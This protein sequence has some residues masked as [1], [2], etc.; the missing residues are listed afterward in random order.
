MVCSSTCSTDAD[1]RLPTAASESQVTSRAP[2]VRSSARLIA[3]STFGPPGCATQVPTSA[4]VMPWSARKLS[5]SAR[6]Y[7]STTSGTVASS[8]IRKPVVPMSQPI[9]RSVS[10][11][12]R[13]RVSTTVGVPAAG[14]PIR[15]ARR[16]PT[17]T[18]AAAPSPKSPLATRLA[19]D[20]SSRCMVREHSSTASRTA[21]SSGCPTR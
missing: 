4:T 2:S 18:T 9:T 1:D 12:I 10:G 14:S 7:F 11:Y 21:T 20:A 19:I 15:S 5:T 6:R 8:T 16:A 3:C 17:M 13:L